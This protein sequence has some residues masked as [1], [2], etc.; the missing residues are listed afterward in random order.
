MSL[1]SLQGVAI[2]IAGLGG[3]FAIGALSAE[4]ERSRGSSKPDAAW[5]AATDIGAG[6][7]MG[8]VVGFM[9]STNVSGL[10]GR[11]ALIGIGVGAVMGGAL[12]AAAGVGHLV[13]S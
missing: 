1:S 10:T 2:A 11:A 9:A 12:G 3:S 6:A 7:T 5:I 8:A 13:A 4:I